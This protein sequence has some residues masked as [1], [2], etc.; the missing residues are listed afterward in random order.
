[1]SRL[2]SVKS[3]KGL[4]IKDPESPYCRKR[5]TYWLKV[6]PE[7]LVVFNA[8]VEEMI[9]ENPKNPNTLT[10]L[11]LKSEDGTRVIIKQFRG[12]KQ[13]LIVAE[14][15]QS[16][17]GRAVEYELDPQGDPIFKRWRPRHTVN[18]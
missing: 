14:W 10:G 11:I 3:S 13:R 1:M 8:T 12:T 18:G 5:D 2:K 7:N 16:L 4:I 6:R 17:I 9:Y 15:G